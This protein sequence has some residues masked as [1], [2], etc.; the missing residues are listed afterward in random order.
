MEGD[1]VSGS[2][3]SM[4][5]SEAS[6]PSVR[7]ALGVVGEVGLELGRRL[8]RTNVKPSLGA[9]GLAEDD[10]DEADECPALSGAFTSCTLTTRER[11]DPAGAAVSVAKGAATTGSLA[12]W[13]SV[14]VTTGAVGAAPASDVGA[15]GAAVAAVS[16]AV[17][18]AA[19][20]EG[21]ALPAADVGG[22]REG[23]ED[24]PG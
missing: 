11:E 6:V 7:C 2:S 15:G 9:V 12:S 22:L 3:A 23:L 20:A 14:K 18:A 13:G 19:G 5:E 10:A 8:W 24:E 16:V 4:S 21:A 17:G 1:S